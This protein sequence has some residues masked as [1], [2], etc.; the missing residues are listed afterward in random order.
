VVHRNALGVERDSK[1]KYGV[2][3]VWCTLVGAQVE[4]CMK[5][6]RRWRGVGG[7]VFSE[8]RRVLLAWCGGT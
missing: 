2:L 4:S 7:R 8:T 1:E 5:V 6:E 3:V